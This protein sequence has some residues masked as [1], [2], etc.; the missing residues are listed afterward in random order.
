MH[1]HQSNV[2]EERLGELAM[3]F[4]GTRNVKERQTIA[5][6]YA[7]TVKRLIHSRAW[8][9]IPGPEDQ[10]PDQWMPDTFFEYWSRPQPTP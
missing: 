5:D 7:D 2:D 6:D 1:H 10:L 9:E 4:R 8:R 3:R